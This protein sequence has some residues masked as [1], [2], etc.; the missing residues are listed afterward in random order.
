MISPG[1]QEVALYSPINILYTN[2]TSV[3]YLWWILGGARIRTKLNYVPRL[4]LG[5]NTKT[6]R[7]YIYNISSQ[8]KCSC[9]CSRKAKI[10]PGSLNDACFRKWE[11]K[12]RGGET[13]YF[14]DQS[15][16]LLDV[17]SSNVSC[18]FGENLLILLFETLMRQDGIYCEVNKSTVARVGRIRRLVGG[19]RQALQNVFSL[20]IIWFLRLLG[21]EF[22]VWVVSIVHSSY[23]KWHPILDETVC[24]HL[25]S[26]PS[27]AC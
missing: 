7:F 26:Q 27:Q 15:P 20:H 21:S 25:C 3:R 24:F 10:C 2:Y 13:E 23:C 5:Q 14:A 19:H 9:I 18:K 17:A 1:H 12:F 4:N 6:H 22:S 8:F 16:V 11:Q